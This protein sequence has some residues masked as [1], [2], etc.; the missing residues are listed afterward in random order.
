[1]SGV[2]FGE[3]KGIVP[4]GSNSEWR[5]ERKSSSLCGMGGKTSKGEKN[6]TSPHREKRNR[7][8]GNGWYGCASIK[9]ETG[10]KGEKK[11]M[12]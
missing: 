10:G 12:Q 11:K 1:M 8:R 6:E 4:S 5:G 3:K 2:Y 9:G 7:G